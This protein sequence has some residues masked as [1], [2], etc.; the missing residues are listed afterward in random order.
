MFSAG[1]LLYL[2]HTGLNSKVT[3]ISS[4]SGGSLTNGM[5]A[6]H[7]DFDKSDPQAFLQSLAPLIARCERGGTVQWTK[8]SKRSLALLALE[9]L[10]LSRATAALIMRPTWKRLALAAIGATAFC[11]SF[12]RTGVMAE[13]VF[14]RLL[15]HSPAGKPVRLASL[16][17]TVTHVFCTTNLTTASQVFFAPTFAH[18]SELGHISSPRLTLAQAVQFSANYPTFAVR[19][20]SARTVGFNQPRLD[21]MLLADGGIFNNMGD[22]WARLYV[23]RVRKNP[24]RRDMGP[25]PDRLMV[26][27]GSSSMT[28]RGR[29]RPRPRSGTRTAH[30]PKKRLL[31]LPYVLSSLP[32]IMRVLFDQSTAARRRYLIELFDLGRMNTL[33]NN[34]RAGAN[35]RPWPRHGTLVHLNT[36]PTWPADH[37]TPPPGVDAKHFAEVA[38]QLR[39]LPD[40]E[41]LKRIVFSNEVL[42]TTLAALPPGSAS[43]L[44]WHGYMLAMVNFR[45][46][47]GGEWRPLRRNY[48]VQAVEECVDQVRPSD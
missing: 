4:V 34:P 8:E 11:V 14:E 35:V 5:L 44:M 38:A 2:A 48:F 47:F 37:N 7:V 41:E 40:F 32:Q 6:L 9:L 39:E 28:Y 33:H 15:F 46:F 13:R 10:A 20:I 36:P 25:V 21:R 26:V 27:N 18:G 31:R 23:D 30:R 16:E 24:H 19:R 43:D 12:A 42:P 22:E 45:V 17:R 29:Y 1:A 3:S